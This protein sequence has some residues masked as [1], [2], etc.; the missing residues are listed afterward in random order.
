[1]RRL[2][3]VFALSGV[4]GLCFELVWTRQLAVVV[5]A[6]SRAVTLVVALFMLGLAI[7]GALGARLAS[8]VRRP[9]RAYAVAEGLVAVSA[10]VAIY[11]LPALES[12]G[13]MAVRLAL[14][15]PLLVV[16]TAAMGLT[17]PFVAQASKADPTT[18]GRLY[19]GNTVGAALGCVL[20]GFLGIGLLGART[21]GLVA[22]AGNALCALLVVAWRDRESAAAHVESRALQPSG[23]ADDAVAVARGPVALAFVCG[24]VALAAEVL[25][26]RALL[27]Y[28]NSSTYT[29][30]TILAVYLGA[31]ALGAL[32]FASRLRG[33]D[34]RGVLR[35]LVGAQLVVALALAASPRWMDVVERSLDVYV[36]IRKVTSAGAWLTGV[37]AVVGR[38]S[39][40]LALPVFLMG[41]SFPAFLRLASRRGAVNG[42]VVGSV[43]AAST[44]GSIVGASLAG[45]VLLPRLG[46]VDS[47]AACGA[48][49]ALV[50]AACALSIVAPRGRYALAL[51]V[52]ALGLAGVFVARRTRVPFLGRLV[53]GTAV[54]LVDEGPQDTTAVVDVVSGAEHGRLIFSNGVSYAG[55]P[56]DSRRYMKLLGH[57]PTLLSDDPSHAIVVCVGTGMTAAAVARSPEVRTLDLIDISPAV[58]RTLP[59]FAHVNDRIE[60]DPRVTIH[61]AD[62]RQFLGRA[63]ERLGVIALEPPPP[64]NAGAASLYTVE[65]YE[66][67]R[68][69]LT[70]GGYVAQWLPLHGL[71]EDELDLL[72]ASFL[73]VFPDAGLFLLNDVEG[74]LVGSPRPLSIDVDRLRARLASDRVRDSLA[75]IGLG[76]ADADGVAAN[77]IALLVTHGEALRAV[78]RTHDLVTDDRPL[79]EQ[80]GLRLGR[81]N[82]GDDAMARRNFLARVLAHASPPPMVGRAPTS[83]AARRAAFLE[84]TRRLVFAAP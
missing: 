59:L 2:P 81:T 56:P 24:A 9:A 44:V 80:F 47:L 38:S 53:E 69:H 82:P 3:W 66:R 36:G 18:V 22:A 45:L 83:L 76:D 11:A 68:R 15:V 49:S 27:P 4:S 78:V 48:V 7:G 51:A 52:A 77:L 30:A 74:A 6:T 32:W 72:T 37:V 28:L 39:L 16:P 63:S 40:V 57:L 34:T 43:G 60:L 21:T 79:I 29:F 67:V 71:T 12:F 26:T 5:G 61:E 75:G 10:V 84:R 46:V 62:G 31:H 20:T 73:Q 42:R 65:L 33:L 41:A 14:A 13:S 1:M 54:V 35:F 25:W 50:A 17:F 23:D 19:A 64:R 70:D 58:R 8:R 55:D